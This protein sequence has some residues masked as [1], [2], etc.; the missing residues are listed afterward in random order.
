M[1]V[2]NRCDRDP[3]ALTASEQRVYAALAKHVRIKDAAESIGISAKT[4]SNTAKVIAEKLGFENATELRA[5]LR[6]KAAA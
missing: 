3:C 1:S 6:G 2:Y 4:A 5:S